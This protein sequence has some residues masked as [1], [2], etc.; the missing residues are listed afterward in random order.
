MIL[1][2]DAFLPN[3]LL[4]GMFYIIPRSHVS[5]PDFSCQN[6]KENNVCC[7]F[8]RTVILT[9]FIPTQISK[10]IRTF[11]I[12]LQR[13]L[14]SGLSV[15]RYSLSVVFCLEIMQFQGPYTYK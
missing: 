5:I 2:D 11:W 9:D 3:W 1:Y 12:V 7:V 6:L 14:V 10:S 4:Q 15:C 8:Y 13:E